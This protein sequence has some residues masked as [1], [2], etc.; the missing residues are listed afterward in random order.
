MPAAR[1]SPRPARPGASSQCGDNCQGA[2]PRSSQART[3]DRMLVCSHVTN[4]LDGPGVI[5]AD[6]QPPPKKA[7]AMFS[8]NLKRS[9]ATL[10]VVAGLLA[11]AVPASA[12]GK[13]LPGAGRRYASG[14]Q[15]ERRRRHALRARHAGRQRGAGRLPRHWH[16]RDTRH[17]RDSHYGRCRV[18]QRQPPRRGHRHHS[19]ADQPQHSPSVRKRPRPGASS[20]AG[21][22]RGAGLGSGGRRGWRNSTDDDGLEPRDGLWPNRGP[23]VPA[24]ALLRICGA[25]PPDRPQAVVRSG[26]RRPP[27]SCVVSVGAACHAGGRRFESGRSR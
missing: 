3:P 7:N 4:L 17:E 23:N 19:L 24:S 6:K 1:W 20:Q 2:R 5:P 18:G 13:G 16:H 15:R 22:R 11:A 25:T 10:G 14:P 26:I 9:V 27:S 21:L 12:G 8:N